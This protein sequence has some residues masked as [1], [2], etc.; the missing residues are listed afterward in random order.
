MHH[1]PYNQIDTLVNSN[2]E[3]NDLDYSFQIRSPIHVPDW[4]NAEWSSNNDFSGIS[5]I[6]KKKNWITNDLKNEIESHY[7]STDEIRINK[8]TRVCTRDIDAFKR[9][10]LKLFPVGRIFMS[11]M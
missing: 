5:T 3:L 10:C 2:K 7:P 4:Y 9:K 6:S 11:N 1:N 8:V